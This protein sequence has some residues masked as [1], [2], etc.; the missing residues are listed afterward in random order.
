MLTRKR[1]SDAQR[2]Q[3]K[4]E[5]ATEVAQKIRIVEQQTK[6]RI[7]AET[8]KLEAAKSTGDAKAVKA[9]ETK[10]A[11]TKEETTQIVQAIQNRF[12]FDSPCRKEFGIVGTGELFDVK[13]RGDTA[14]SRTTQRAPSTMLFTDAQQN[15][16]LEALLDLMIFSMGHS[17][18]V[19]SDDAIRNLWVNAR[20]GVEH[21][22]DLR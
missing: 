20:R 2:E 5:I 18:H 14:F 19:V 16:E 13:S 10:I 17:E 9:I 12:A 8:I 21:D 22:Q 6:A 11:V 15:P 1:V 7:E 4:Q 3:A